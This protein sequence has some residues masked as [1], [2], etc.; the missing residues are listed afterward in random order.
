[1]SLLFS[2]AQALTIPET[3]DLLYSATNGHSWSK[4]SGWSDDYEYNYCEWPG[5]T[6]YNVD[7]YNEMYRQIEIS[8]VVFVVSV[9]LLISVA[10]TLFFLQIEQEL[11]TNRVASLIVERQ[12]ILRQVE[13][14]PAIQHQYKS[15]FAAKVPKQK[16]FLDSIY[17]Y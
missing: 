8:I 14:T 7:R 4:N 16:D 13:L 6:C 3:L 1:M 10:T 5:I 17:G 12:Q 15:L 9:L 2:G 11:V